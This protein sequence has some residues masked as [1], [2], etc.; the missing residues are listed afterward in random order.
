MSTTRVQPKLCVFCCAVPFDL[1]TAFGVNVRPLSISLSVHDQVKK[2]KSQRVDI[3]HYHISPRGHLRYKWADAQESYRGI[4]R[5]PDN[6][7]FITV[8]REP[9]SHFLRY[10]IPAVIAFVPQALDSSSRVC[11]TICQRASSLHHPTVKS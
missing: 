10:L 2:K 11:C 6:I 7:N 8:M 3:M 9:R 4:M 5:D 1:R